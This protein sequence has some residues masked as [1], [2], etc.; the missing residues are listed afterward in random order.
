M[1]KGARRFAEIF[2]IGGHGALE[3]VR[4]QIADSGDLHILLALENRDN[5]IEFRTAIADTDMPER[6][7]VVGPDDA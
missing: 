2:F 5:P 1:L 3:V 6:N 7:P 4:P